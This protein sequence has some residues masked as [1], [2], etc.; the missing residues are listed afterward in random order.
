[1]EDT[2]KAEPPSSD[3]LLIILRMEESRYCIFPTLF[4]DLSLDPRNGPA[5][6]NLLSGSPGICITGSTHVVN[7]PIASSTD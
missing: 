7:C 6:E 2:V 5:I 1:M 3:G 4:D